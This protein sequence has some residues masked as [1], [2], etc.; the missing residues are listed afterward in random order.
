ML[1]EYF[2]STILYP[3]QQLLDMLPVID[4]KLPEGVFD[5]LTNIMAYISYFLPMDA[6][7]AI[8]GIDLSLHA[9]RLGMAFIVRLK[10]FI[11]GLGS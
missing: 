6:V 5:I 7:F 3:V 8:I 9:F 11:V 4:F 10:S 1:I 2:F